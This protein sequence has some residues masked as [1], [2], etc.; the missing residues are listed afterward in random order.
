MRQAVSSSNPFLDEVVT[1]LITAGGK[2]LR[3]ALTIAAAGAVQGSSGTQT[4]LDSAVYS[5]AAAVEL[6]HLGSLHHDD[7]IDEAQ[8]RRNVE[9]VNARYGNAMAILSGDFLMARASGLVAELGGDV[10]QVLAQTI[11]DLVMGQVLEWQDHANT[12]RTVE[13]YEASING[14]TASLLAD[15]THLGALTGGGNADQVEKLA[16]FGRAFG[17][18]F[19]I[20]DDISDVTSTAEVMGKPVGNDLLEG[21]YSLPTIYALQDNAVASELQALLNEDIDTQGIE[22]ACKLI[23]HSNAIERAE[24]RCAMWCQTADE[25]LS[26]IANSKY[27]D[28]LRELLARVR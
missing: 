6:T 7:V 18:A 1:H 13:S 17:M 22:Q 5:A 10:P 28:A 25:S 11:T 2:R 24:Q 8:Q 21:T 26:N 23:Q 19:Q 12:A 27:T 4:D 3:P 20:R 14:K 15:S 9:S 16:S